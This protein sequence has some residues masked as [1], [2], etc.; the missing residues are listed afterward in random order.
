MVQIYFHQKTENFFLLSTRIEKKI[1]G[2][3]AHLT[4]PVLRFMLVKVRYDRG[5]NHILIVPPLEL[6]VLWRKA[7]TLFY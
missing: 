6:C 2:I 3:F 1:S 5:Q 7:L 4:N